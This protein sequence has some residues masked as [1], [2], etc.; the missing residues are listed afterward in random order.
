M[1]DHA[2]EIHNIAVVKLDTLL[3][4]RVGLLD[5]SWPDSAVGAHGLLAGEPAL[6][7]V[8]RCAG[9][10]EAPGGAAHLLVFEAV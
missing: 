6:R 7:E 1:L 10:A 5:R 8:V 2:I 4:L 3:L 9:A